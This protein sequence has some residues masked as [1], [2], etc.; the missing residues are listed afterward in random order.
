MFEPFVESC[1]AKWNEDH[2]I[3][4]PSPRVAYH[5]L[6]AVIVSRKLETIY[7]SGNLSHDCLRACPFHQ[8]NE[9]QLGHIRAK[10]DEGCK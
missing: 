10:L 8:P 2:L 3:V 7:D 5:D 9:Q 4:L 6:P 1:E